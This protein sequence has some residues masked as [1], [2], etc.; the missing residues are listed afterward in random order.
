MVLATLPHPHK[1]NMVIQILKFN[2]EQQ[3]VTHGVDD[4]IDLKELA[5]SLWAAKFVILAFALISTL[6]AVVYAL[7]QKPQYTARAIFE[8]TATNKGP[9]LPSELSGL[10]SLAGLNT[11][12][13]SKGL[14]DRLVGRD[15]VVRLDQDVN[16]LEDGYFNPAGIAASTI[17]SQAID[18]L[19]GLLS[20][21]GTQTIS[22]EPL[23]GDDYEKVVKAYLDNVSVTET[24]NG[25]IEIS[26]TH[27]DPSRAAAITNAIV[28]RAIN[29]TQSERALEQRKQL[30]YL[31]GELAK[32]LAEMDTA[33]RAVAEFALAN[34]LQASG[35]FTQR[36]SLMANLRDDLQKTLEMAV[37]VAA[38]K[39][40]LEN[41]A[42]PTKDSYARLRA[43]FPVVDD[44][45]FRRLLG[46][47]EALNTWEFPSLA[48]LS[49][50]ANT[51][52]DRSARIRRSINE[53]SQ[54]AEE[55]A[56]SNEQLSALKREAVFAEAAYSVLMEQV[57]VQAV[58]S[59][60]QSEPAKLYQSAVA[61]SEPSAPK[62]SLIA[63]LGLILGSF[64]GAAIA[65]L[66]HA[67]KGIV[68]SSQAIAQAL[69]YPPSKKMPI[70]T[71]VKGTFQSTFNKISRLPLID[72]GEAHIAISKY[73]K[74]P[75]I[76][77]ATGPDINGLP[78][79]LWLANFIYRSRARSQPDS[80]PIGVLI[81]GG[82]VPSGL[83]LEQT[84]EPTLLSTCIENI[85][86][87]VPSADISPTEMLQETEF[88]KLLKNDDSL[89]HDGL[90]IVASAEYSPVTLIALSETAT[91]SLAVTKPGKSDRSTIDKTSKYAD[92][93]A[94]ICL[95]K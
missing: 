10:A 56:A 36:S 83:K 25:S 64:I 59:G 33:K 18:A 21:D 19:K 95:E 67:R 11:T 84:T 85:R 54:E 29:E 35:E 23:I 41:E 55:Y 88:Q 6:I 82:T 15:F 50:F 60:Y 92:W 48:R 87:F 34:S 74:R 20:P 81:I 66:A 78:F 4:E 24:S 70:D 49:T 61:P 69:G 75:I 9:S 45:D 53:L 14:F 52:E 94:N 13:N 8:I 58:S 68:Y 16:L 71:R 38:V 3:Q 47:P 89:E 63:A 76:V 28:Q 7:S 51:L 42:S 39:S 43:Q 73:P 1:G 31:S 44:V 90:I 86:L 32:A 37:G 93:T 26:V 80:K 77:A 91:I 5:L 12:S 62:K 30:D 79:S 17:K 72:L 46:I 57:K 27:N 40:L 22:Q 2:S 65:L